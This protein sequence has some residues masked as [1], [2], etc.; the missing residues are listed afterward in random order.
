ML[1]QRHIAFRADASSRVGIGHVMR[2]LSLADELRQRGFVTHFVTRE[3]S[4]PLRARVCGAGHD[5]RVLPSPAELE[6]EV[7]WHP[8]VQRA[9]ADASLE[10]VAAPLAAIVVDHYALGHDWEARG[11]A[12]GARLVA[13]DDLGR[14]HA[15]DVL[16]DQNLYADGAARYAGRVPG[17]SRVLIGPE[18]ALLRA[19]FARLRRMAA[20]RGGRGCRVFVLFGGGDALDLTSR[21]LA[22]IELLGRDDLG[23]D[24][25]IGPG[26]PR[27]DSIVAECERRGYACHVDSNRVAELMVAADIAL[28]ASGSASWERCCMGLPCV[29]VAIARNQEEIGANL[30]RAGVVVHL[31]TAQDVTA[32]RMASALDELARDG[33]RLRDMSERAFQLVDGGGCGR[34]ADVIG[35]M[36]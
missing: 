7:A 26:H 25:V 18:Y 17:G 33:A 3:M 8:E 9:D 24:V 6:P 4:E 13:I 10:S 30:E 14:E 29:S 31:G 23:V 21:A 5:L 35:G 12:R 19:E 22:A 20:V 11:A 2:C 32:E 36:A 28:G 1:G 27:R 34:V 15:C 16:L